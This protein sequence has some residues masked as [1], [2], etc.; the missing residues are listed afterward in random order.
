MKEIAEGSGFEIFARKGG[1]DIEIGETQTLGG[2][3]ELLKKKLKSGLQA[4]GFIK[5]KGGEKLSFAELGGFGPD[6][7]ISKKDLFRVV[8][9][10]QKRL[11]KAT[12]G[13]DIQFFRKQKKNKGLFN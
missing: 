10:K 2:A 1:I 5:T 6:F 9:L 11:R 13:K 12:T 3:K 7:R 4:S 8:E